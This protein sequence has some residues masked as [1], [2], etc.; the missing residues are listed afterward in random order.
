MNPS[1]LMYI[2]LN[3]IQA[4][5][6]CR[7]IAPFLH[8]RFLNVSALSSCANLLWN[9]HTLFSFR[10]PAT[11]RSTKV[12]WHDPARC[13]GFHLPVFSLGHR[14]HLLRPCIAHLGGGISV[15]LVK[16]ELLIYCLAVRNI[17]VNLISIVFNS[18]LI[19]SVV[20]WF[21]S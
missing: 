21:C 19:L 8:N 9:I 5:L 18:F 7:N 15:C 1:L 10:N 14:A 3:K 12:S 13:D 17:I 4:S 20:T 11:S 6:P 2:R 16:T